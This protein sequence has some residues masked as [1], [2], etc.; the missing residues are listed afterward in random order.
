M[1]NHGIRFITW[2][3]HGCFNHLLSILILLDHNPMGRDDKLVLVI[4]LVNQ[5]SAIKQLCHR[6]K[7][8]RVG[9]AFNGYFE[10]INWRVSFVG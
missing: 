9:V 1:V 10:V 8:R 3:N 2:R 6:V 4:K 7:F 5:L